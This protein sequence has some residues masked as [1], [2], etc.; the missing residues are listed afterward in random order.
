MVKLLLLEYAFEP[1]ESLKRFSKISKTR[2]D[3]SNL[4]K[5]ISI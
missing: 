4:L 5:K 2:I 3:N 1:E